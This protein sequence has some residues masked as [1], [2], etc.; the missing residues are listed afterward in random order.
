[1]INVSNQSFRNLENCDFLDREGINAIQDAF[2]MDLCCVLE[3]IIEIRVIAVGC[4]VVIRNVTIG[5]VTEY[6]VFEEQERGIEEALLFSVN[7]VGSKPCGFFS[8]NN[9]ELQQSSR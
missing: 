4:L 9:N 1:M 3:R 2:R 6:E 7:R 8:M 5:P